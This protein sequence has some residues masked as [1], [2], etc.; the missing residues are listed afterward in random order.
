MDLLNDLFGKRKIGL[1]LSGGGA[2]G[3]AHLGVLK[4]IDEKKIKIDF[5]CGTSS[6]S[7]IGALYASG[8]N[9]NEI[10][11]RAQKIRW[12]DIAKLGMSKTG[13]VSSAG[14]EM[15]LNGLIGDKLFADLKIP[16]AV[17]STDIKTGEKV[18]IKK[19]NVALAVR[20]SCSFPGI[21][22]ATMHDHRLLVDGAIIEN[23]PVDTV[24]ELGA[25]YVIAVDVIPNAVL[26]ENPKNIMVAADRAVDI[27]L[28]AQT[29]RIIN[30]PDVLIEPVNC[31]V[32]S[33]D[34]DQKVKLMQMGEKAAREALAY[35]G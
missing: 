32:T 5:I 25:N 23:M 30:Q 24:R 8:M 6:G 15:Y 3:F 16:F 33:M 18:V 17:V 21:Y 19:G 1:A 29:K 11:E 22:T 31:D 26:K 12:K 7:L 14:I 20:A 27:I 35:F 34:L 10:I 13:L 2:R 9:I 4:V 28:K